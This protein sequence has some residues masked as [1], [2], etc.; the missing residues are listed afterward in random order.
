MKLNLSSLCKKFLIKISPFIELKSSEVSEAG[1]LGLSLGESY[2]EGL[3]EIDPG[4][5]RLPLKSNVSL[6]LDSI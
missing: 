6:A 1:V 4:Y 3:P 2:E 5:S